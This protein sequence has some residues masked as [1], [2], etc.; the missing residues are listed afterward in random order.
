MLTATRDA[1]TFANKARL[2]KAVLQAQFTP[3]RVNQLKP[4]LPSPTCGE[5][6]CCNK[7]PTVSV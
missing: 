7:I 5:Y 6:R 4:I 2:S 1:L 3:S